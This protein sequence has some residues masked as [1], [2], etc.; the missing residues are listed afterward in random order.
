MASVNFLYRSTKPK[1]FL[2][3]RLLFRIT[4]QKLPKGYK[5]FS[6]GGKTKLEISRHYWEKEHLQIRFKRTNDIDELNRIQEL[7]EKQNSINQELN[8]FE[9]HIL[10]SFNS[11]DPE[12]ISKEWLQKTINEYYNPKKVKEKPE[13]LISY[14]EDY[15]EE[16]KEHV[17]P[18]TV[19]K[20]NVIKQMLVKFQ[21]SLDHTIL[22]KD[23]DLNFKRDFEAYMLEKGYA[24]NT[25]ARAIKFT[26][27]VARH[28]YSQGLETSRQL[29]RIKTKTKES[30]KIYLTFEE[31]EKI[32][33]KSFT[34]EHLEI[35]RDWLII[36]CFTGQRISDFMRFTKDMIRKKDDKFLLEFTQKKTGKVMTIPLL[37]QVR[38]ILDKRNG[39]FPKPLPDPK[40]NEYIKVVCKKAG[41]KEEVWGS[42]KIEVAEKQFRK[43]SD[44]YEKWKLVTSHIG[45]RSFATNYYGEVPLS[46]LKTIT[47]HHTERNFMAYL[48]KGDEE[49]AIDALKYFD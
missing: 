11:T 6:L 21:N 26:K 2:N 5:D 37:K 35:A 14:V 7:K 43:K 47:G 33:K 3:L 31:L 10:Q 29:D 49:K 24:Y 25:I 13:D 22:L 20:S 39:E 30:E 48:G 12:K 19:K 36:S 41:L 34:K 23:I 17:S 38:E 28:A 32:K 1:A 18:A 15:I 40:Y 46:H 27:T 4:D 9:S 16:R 44:F 42:K 8:K 45:R